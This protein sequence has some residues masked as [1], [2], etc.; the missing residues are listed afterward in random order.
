MDADNNLKAT[1][2]YSDPVTVNNETK[3]KFENTYNAAPYKAT[4]KELFQIEKELKD[5][6]WNDTDS[7]YFT[8]SR[9]GNAPLPTRTTASVN[10]LNKTATIGGDQLLE[11]KTAD[12]YTYYISENSGSIP[13]VTYD[14]TRYKV[15]V[16]VKDNGNGELKGETKYYKSD[17]NGNF[18]EGEIIE[19]ETNN[20]AKFTN[21]YCDR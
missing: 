9:A 13:G 14:K 11:F 16:T 21:T 6:D 17:S 2:E 5:R 12:T 18:T 10:H 8:L 1:V 19:A 7:F 15:V 4:A 3:A 20:V